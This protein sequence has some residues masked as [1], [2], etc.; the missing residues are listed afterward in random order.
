[1]KFRLFLFLAIS[2]NVVAKDIVIKDTDVERIADAI[3]V[4]EGGKKTKYPYGIKSINTG[5][6]RVKARSICINTIRNTHKRWIAANK[7]IDFLD[8]LANRYCPHSVDKGG[9][10]RWKKNIRKY[11]VI[12]N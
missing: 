3:Y 9:N 8:Y 10:D 6:N 7:P 12:K 1:M 4:I 2:I 5:G 11:V